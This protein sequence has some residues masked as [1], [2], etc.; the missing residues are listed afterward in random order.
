M[1]IVSGLHEEQPFFGTRFGYGDFELHT[2]TSRKEPLMKTN[3]ALIAG[4]MLLA[5]ATAVGSQP[6][7]TAPTQG[8]NQTQSP[9][10]A[11][12]PT[13]NPKDTGQADPACDATGKSSSTDAKSAAPS[14]KVGKDTGDLPPPRKKAPKDSACPTQP[15]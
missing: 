1:R 9:V 12:Q 8:A 5:P 6:T 4:V 3:L 15:Q 2:S 7:Q 10:N 11:Q 13:A 14:P